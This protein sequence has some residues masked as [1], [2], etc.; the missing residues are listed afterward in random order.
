MEIIAFKYGESLFS[1]EKIFYKDNRHELVPFSWLFYLI[2]NSGKFIL[3]DTGFSTEMF[4]ERYKIENYENPLKILKNNNI[5]PE[6]ITDLIIT[7]AHFDH[8]GNIS[9]FPHA[10]IFIQSD[11]LKGLSKHMDTSRFGKQIVEFNDKLEIGNTGISV[12]K[13]GGHTSGSSIVKVNSAEGDIIITGDEAYL[14]ENIVKDIPIGTYHNAEKNRLFIKSLN[15]SIKNVF[16]FHDPSIVPAK[17]QY[18]IFSF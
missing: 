7:H 13:I 3:V 8:V 2:K 12:V 1:T 18:K 5:Q 15:K 10:S 14:Y 9:K 4:I 17:E 6:E 16:T 11:E